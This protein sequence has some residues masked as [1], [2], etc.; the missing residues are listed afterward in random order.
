MHGSNCRRAGSGPLVTLVVFSEVQGETA[1]SAR[2]QSSSSGDATPAQKARQARRSA[3]M[4]ARIPTGSVRNAA[5][6]PKEYAFR[7]TRR[8]GGRAARQRNS[9]MPR[10]PRQT[11][12]PARGQAGLRWIWARGERFR[13][14][15]LFTG[16]A[17]ACES[18]GRANRPR[19]CAR[20]GRHTVPASVRD[21]GKTSRES[22]RSISAHA[23]GVRLFT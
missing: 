13:R 2:C 7:G 15:T 8:A 18:P 9:R 10:L 1:A 22:C 12:H 11:I 5:D 20:C 16:Y 4:L 19:T 23:T 3:A 14:P 6:G 21:S 17:R